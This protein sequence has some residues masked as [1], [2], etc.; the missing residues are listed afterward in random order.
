MRG[1]FKVKGFVSKGFAKDSVSSEYKTLQ[2]NVTKDSRGCTV[3]IGSPED[4][5]QLTIPFDGILKELNRR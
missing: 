2:V 4:D 1:T 5:I 3:S